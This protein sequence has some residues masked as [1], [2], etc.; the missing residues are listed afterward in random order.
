MK[1]IFK[2][3]P[4]IQTSEDNT[5]TSEKTEIYFR[6][7][8]NLTS[9]STGG[10]ILNLKRALSFGDFLK[11]NKE[12]MID[13]SLSEY[14]M[15]LLNQKNLKRSDVVRDS[16]IDSSFVYQ[17]FNG[18]KK[19]S[20]DKL[21]A[22]GFGLHLNEKEFQRML[23][24]AGHSELYPRVARDALILLSIHQGKD[25]YQTDHELYKYNFTTLLSE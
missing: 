17:I 14:L 5:Y 18:E 16:G 15:M 12:N 21:I 7:L 10:S 3:E 22:I 4:S 24:I 20:R 25:I 8:D 19:A 23:K 13:M 9:I 2:S 11:K 1:D 6:E